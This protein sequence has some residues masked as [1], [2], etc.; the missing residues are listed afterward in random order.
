MNRILVTGSAGF[1]GYHLCRS[2]LNDDYEV[3]G[4]DNL[5]EYYDPS[6]KLARLE[7]LNHYKNFTFEKV[8]IA[9]R[10]SLTKSFQSFDP[11]ELSL[12]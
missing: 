9:D 1:I 4:I 7:Q 5:N 2:L 6:I 11:L 10:E 8:D 3:L 12:R